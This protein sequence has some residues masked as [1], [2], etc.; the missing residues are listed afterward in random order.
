MSSMTLVRQHKE[1]LDLFARI[2]GMAAENIAG[3]SFEILMKL[4]ELSGK[5]KIHLAQEDQVLYPALLKHKEQ[6]VRET[7]QRFMQEMGGLS[8]AFNQF[9]RRYATTAAI[10]ENPRQFLADI[11]TITVA[12][13][14]RIRAEEEELYPLAK[15][16]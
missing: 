1:I 10:K 8:E 4:G 2:E 6:Q 3:R 11:K 14:R 9:K 12:L 7:A 5:V 15:G 16:V 13:T